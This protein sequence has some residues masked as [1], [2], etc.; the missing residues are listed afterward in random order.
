MKKIVVVASHPGAGQTTL[1]VNL[2]SGLAN[3][4]HRILI[5]AGEENYKLYDY[6]GVSR[7]DD[8]QTSSLGVD[9]ISF[10][11]GIY[12][13][14]VDPEEYEF[15]FLIPGNKKEWGLIIDRYDHLLVCIDFTGETEI[16]ELIT[17]EKEI[18][19]LSA[20]QKRISLIVPNKMNSKEWEHNSQELF[21][22]ADYFGADKIADPIPACERVHDLPG[23]KKTVWQINRQNLQN[24][25]DRLIE[26][27]EFL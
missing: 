15:V 23:L 11:Q 4:G 8:I 26:K 7:Q 12:M 24:A 27:V 25:F 16:K 21:T 18:Q 20:E 3:K 17:L 9:I 14:D 6:L 10:A 5:A 22:L 13:Y 2:G 1:A 19:D